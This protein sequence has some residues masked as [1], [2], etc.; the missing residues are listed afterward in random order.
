MKQLPNPE[1]KW[2]LFFALLVLP[3]A[4]RAQVFDT[5][6]PKIAHQ[7][8]R[9][10]RVGKPLPITANVSDNAGVKSVRITIQHDGQQIE[11]E[12]N[13][14]ASAASVPVVVQT[15]TEAVAVYSTPGNTGKQLGQLTPGELLEVTL[16]RAPY[17]R[18][19]SAT[20]LT[21]YIPADA[22]QTVESGAAYRITLP[23]AL[24]AGGRLAYQIA[25]TDDFG[26][27][28]KTELIPIRLLTDAEIARLQ[29]QRGGQ[30]PP[31]RSEEQ[32]AAR[33]AAKG[34]AAKS[35]YS[36]P[37]FWITTAAIGGGIIYMLASGDDG[38]AP[39]KAAVGV[40]IGW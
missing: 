3:L 19:R 8:V 1:T 9:L 36:K 32:A 29:G 34:S 10:G 21:G 28:S 40:T 24:T 7:P 39:K 31:A 2:R 18:I 11:H 16:V 15:G 37:A 5:T 6:P 30:T 23:A 27:E 25:A 13:A 26:N 22:V 17:Y 12:M 33:P 14:V 38:S 20:G 35:L 4:A